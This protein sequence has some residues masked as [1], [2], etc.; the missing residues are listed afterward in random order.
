MNDDLIDLTT[1]E[2]APSEPAPPKRKRVRWY[3]VVVLGVAV[4]VCATAVGFFT[5]QSSERDDATAQRTSAQARLADQRDDTDAASATLESERTDMKR[6][7]AKVEAVTTSLHEYSDLVSQHVDEVAQSHAIALRL[8]DS[9][10]E[11]NAA[12]DR[13]NGSIAQM[14]AKADAILQQIESFRDETEA[15]YTVA[16]SSR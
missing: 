7:L 15:Q 1:A 9:V 2:P 11:F 3:H 10:D 13:A 12:V 6:A 4:L 14:Q 16:T 8:P 5:N